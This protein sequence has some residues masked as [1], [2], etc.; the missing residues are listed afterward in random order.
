MPRLR[1]IGLIVLMLFV[2]PVIPGCDEPELTPEQRSWLWD[3]EYLRRKLLCEH[4]DP[5]FVITEEEFDLQMDAIKD[6]LVGLS[7]DEFQVG[8]MQ[9][10]ASL[11]D[12][13]T[14][15][16]ASLEDRARFPV[17]FRWF[18]DGLYVIRV[19]RVH[20]E[21]LGGRVESIQGHSPD[22][23][24]D[25][26]DSIIPSETEGWLKSSIMPQIVTRSILQALGVIDGD[27]MTVAV[28]DAE[29]ELVVEKLEASTE[30]ADM[31]GVLDD[32]D[33][34]LY[35]SNT[36]LNFWYESVPSERLLY[37]QYN[38]CVDAQRGSQEGPSFAEVFEEMCD[39]AREVEVDA[40]IVDLR[41]NI[42]GNSSIATPFFRTLLR[43]GVLR[44]SRG[45]NLSLKGTMFGIIGWRTISSGRIHAS[46]LKLRNRATMFGEPT[47]GLINSYGNVKS[48]ELPNTGL[49]IRHSTRLIH[50]QR[51]SPW[52]LEEGT[53]RRPYEPHYLVP[54]T[55][56]DYAAGRDP[57]VAA[58]LQYVREE[59]R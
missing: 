21:I 29:G 16:M 34:P 12:D 15:L 58:I 32:V 37:F 14:S 19:A 53:F 35:L 22:E 30:T 33:L 43:A 11:G 20:A 10:I 3:L 38:R 9:L 41:F 55:F 18:S 26:L 54:L 51:E 7:Y 39:F 1:T 31:V 28:I 47:G 40:F 24:M 4:P 59:T 48:F 50:T 49:T 8:L 57:V 52:T 25:A 27:F 45:H 23:I 44:D 2:L 42:G 36:H 46:E 6:G 17:V 5:F 56:E 13:H